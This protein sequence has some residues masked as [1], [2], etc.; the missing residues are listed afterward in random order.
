MCRFT[1]PEGFELEVTHF[2]QY[3]IPETGTP[4]LS[5][6]PLNPDDE[7]CPHGGLCLVDVF[8]KDKNWITCADALCSQKDNYNK[9]IGRL[10]ATGRALKLVSSLQ[11]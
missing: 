4:Y 3:Q 9:K 6:I 1:L 11:T 5:D 10:I 8:D 7:L 2:R